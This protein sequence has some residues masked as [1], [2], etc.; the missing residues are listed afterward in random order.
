VRLAL[1]VV[2]QNDGGLCGCNTA[3]SLSLLPS[4]KVNAFRINRACLDFEY[5]LEHAGLFFGR[6]SLRIYAGNANTG[7]GLRVCCYSLKA[8]FTVVLCGDL[9]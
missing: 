1:K 5:Y 8:T 2:V 3:A 6:C 9:T 4:H 7:T